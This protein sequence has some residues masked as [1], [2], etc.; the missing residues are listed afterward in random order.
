MKTLIATVAVALIIN[1]ICSIDWGIDNDNFLFLE[2]VKRVLFF[3]ALGAG[4]LIGGLRSMARPE[5]D[6]R[7]APW[8]LAGIAVALFVF[9]LHNLIDF[10][11]FEVGPMYTAA[12]LL[13]AALGA[14][15][16]EP[17]TRPA[18]PL[19][20]AAF[21]MTSLALVAAAIFFVAPVIE[22]ESHAHAADQFIR[23]S[24][25]PHGGPIDPAAIQSAV[26]HLDEAARLV[27]YNA[28]YFSRAAHAM[29]YSD[30]LTP[31]ILPLLDA[32][33]AT[34]P[35]DPQNYLTRGKYEAT[36]AN[37]DWDKALA[38]DA[39]ALRLDPYN[40]EVRLAYAETLQAL[41]R[42]AEAKAQYEL[43]LH[44]NSLYD[45]TEPKRLS[46]TKVAEIEKT[47]ESLGATSQ[48][49]R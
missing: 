2:A 11:A 38:D 13:G 18:G 1:L 19:S 45:P 4:L 49:A 24:M 46:K 17:S 48:P 23:A 42:N 26:D 12:L 28:D 20:I 37:P 14:R 39:H 43:L 31:Q 33:I 35:A 22:A 8:A 29:A 3:V 6:D 27:P 9:L 36:Q 10:S 47:M 16:A 34:D 5:S 44:N 7:A 25:N 15:T 41:L 32:A 21:A 30:R 40:L